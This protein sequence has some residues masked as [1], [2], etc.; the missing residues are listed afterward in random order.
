MILPH[1]HCDDGKFFEKNIA[2]HG[3]VS[4]S[5]LIINLTD[6]RSESGLKR[7]DCALLVSA[8]LGAAW[9]AAVLGI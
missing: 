1:I 9:G 2:R 5:D 4:G 7:G 3:H 6:I 8:G